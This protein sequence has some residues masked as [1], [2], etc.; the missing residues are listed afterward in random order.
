[1]EWNR[2]RESGSEL[3]S[4][5][6]PAA[7]G[8][9]LHPVEDPKKFPPKFVWKVGR[10][11][12]AGCVVL[13]SRLQVL[14]GMMGLDEM[15][16]EVGGKKKRRDKKVS[17]ACPDSPR[18][19]RRRASSSQMRQVQRTVQNFRLDDEMKGKQDKTKLH[20]TLSIL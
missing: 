6:M 9:L 18:K 13:K 1:M 20:V 5:V 8:G 12:C 7:V 19:R 2:D 15:E 4:D 16:I 11:V 14:G 17:D 3:R 10:Q